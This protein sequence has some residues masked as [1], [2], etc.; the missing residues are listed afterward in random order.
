VASH[1][2]Y[3]G[4]LAEGLSIVKGV[5]DRH[6]GLRR[7]P[8]NE[9]ECGSHYARSMASWGLITALAGYEFD[10]PR[11]RVGFSPRIH[12]DDFGVFWSLD[13][14]WGSYVQRLSGESARVELSVAYGEL[15]LRELHLGSIQEVHSARVSVDGAPISATF[16]AENTGWTV[17]FG[18]EL[19]LKP[20]QGLTIETN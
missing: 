9:F 13:S 2:I 16:A 1:L 20:G 7:N 18:E 5:R 14:G 8:W 10:A 3:E 15:S 12:V 6:D 19:L 17:L 11:A 4:F